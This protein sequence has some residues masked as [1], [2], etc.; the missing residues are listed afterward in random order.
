MKRCPQC[1]FLYEEDQHQCDMDGTRLV[2]DSTVLI[3]D[4]NAPTRSVGKLFVQLGL[5]LVVLSV[6]TLYAFKHQAT[7]T[8]AGLRA[9]TESPSAAAQS[10][11]GSSSEANSP[12][13]GPSEPGKSELS[14]ATGED[15]TKMTGAK[16]NDGA[17]SSDSNLGES[18]DPSIRMSKSPRSE[19]S[20]PS[21][22]SP[23]PRSRP[24]PKEKDSKV[25]SFLKKTGRFLKKPFQN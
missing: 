10:N 24:S 14:P 25:T 4:S 11:A 1:E 5:P 19:A 18:S 8:H 9:V 23:R 17:N 12:S 15:A 13:R 2:H 22:Q 7:A 6:L 20:S 21:R 3:N 16:D